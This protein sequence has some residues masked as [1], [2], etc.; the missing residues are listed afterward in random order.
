MTLTELELLVIELRKTVT[1]LEFRVTGLE[2][3]AI[4]MPK[5]V[6]VSVAK[7]DPR[8]EPDGLLGSPVSAPPKARRSASSQQIVRQHL[9][10]AQHLE[11]VLDHTR[12]ALDSIAEGSRAAIVADK[13]EW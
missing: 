6:E 5:I 3:D 4:P 11:R 1:Q 12:S 7:P 9:T 10:A 8:A 13:E 2:L